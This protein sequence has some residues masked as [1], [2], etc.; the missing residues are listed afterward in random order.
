MSDSANIKR[1]RAP[2]ALAH[3]AAVAAC[4]EYVGGKETLGA[5]L[6]R[7]CL[8]GSRAASLDAEGATSFET[9]GP[10]SRKVSAA[11]GP[12]QACRIE[13]AFARWG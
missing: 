2:Q 11:R 1:A 7:C 10:G 5:R 9:G 4:R 13:A 3:A 8:A 6:P 12:L